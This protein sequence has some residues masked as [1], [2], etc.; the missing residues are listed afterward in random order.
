MSGSLPTTER[1][2]FDKRY[3]E[4]EGKREEVSKTE[5][6]YRTKTLIRT[7]NGIRSEGVS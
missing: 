4:C 1:Q 2:A 6:K 5:L 3:I 7:I